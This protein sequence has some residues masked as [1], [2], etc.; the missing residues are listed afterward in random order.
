MSRELN[1]TIEQALQSF[2][3]A[4]QRMT[5]CLANVP[6][7]HINWSPSPTSRTPVEQV[8]HSAGAVK[9]IHDTLMGDMFAVPT[10]AEADIGFRSWE[11]RFRSRKDVTR[12][13]ERYSEDYVNWLQTLEAND[14]TK[15]I[16]M[17][18]G[19][20]QV[21]LSLAITFPAAHMNEHSAQID[22]IQTIHGDRD[23]HT[24]F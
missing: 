4:K 3:A 9:M 23:W 22:Y 12:L 21:P 16:E 19:M 14:L 18:F 24:G 17:P 20:G 8:A 15:M 1:P 5:N 7:E 2:L 6:D 10:S 13:L 11:A